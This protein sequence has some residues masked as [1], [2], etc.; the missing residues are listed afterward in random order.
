M[1][2]D[3][4]WRRLFEVNMKLLFV[5]V[6]NSCRSQMAEGLAKSMGFEASSA[7]THPAQTVAEHAITLLEGKGI[8]TDGMTPKSLD[9]F[10]PSEFDMV[11]SMG[12]GVHCPAIKI[13]QD[14]ELE[15]PVGQ[16]YVVYETTAAEIQRRLHLL[17]SQ[18]S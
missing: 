12:C 18:D 14:W 17:T 10:N 6:G 1:E 8:S 7:G 16:A 15:D 3:F 4:K 11:I 5:C 2:R 9:H 13:D